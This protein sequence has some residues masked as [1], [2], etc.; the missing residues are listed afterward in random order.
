MNKQIIRIGH[1]SGGRL[2]NALISEIFLK[3]F[4]NPLLEELS[5]SVRIPAGDHEMAFTTDS[6][7]IDPVFFPG[8]DIGQLAISGTVNDLSVSG[9]IPKYLSAGFI[10]EEGFP[11]EDLEKIVI[12]MA[13]EAGNAGI[14]IVT[15]DTKVVKKGQCDKLFINTSGIGIVPKNRTH[16]KNRDSISAGDKIIVTGDLGDHAI[17][18]L[19][20]RENLSLDETILS[21]ASPLNSMVEEV[22]TSPDDIKFMRDITR[23]GLATILVETCRRRPFGISVREN[24]IPVKQSVRAVCELYGYEPIY[25]ANEGKIMM[26]VKEDKADAVLQTLRQ[27]MNGRC[28]AIIGEITSGHPGKVVMLSSV[29]G[30]RMVDML[31]GEMLPRI[32]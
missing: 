28:A 3:H 29:G 20:A 23:G 22:L 17:A 1:G 31:S 24:D 10:I 6:Y 30:K 5:D 27:H 4:H 19:A 18:I 15:G 9:A 26:V 7:V 13:G 25:L 16:L 32:C 12:S 2:S 14:R 8:G 21:D 11:L